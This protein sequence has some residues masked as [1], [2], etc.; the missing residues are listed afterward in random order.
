MSPLNPLVLSAGVDQRLLLCNPTRF[1][2]A[3]PASDSRTSNVGGADDEIAGY[4]PVLFIVIYL[5][6]VYNAAQTFILEK[7]SKAREG[8]RMQG[9]R[10]RYCWR[11]GCILPRVPA[12]SLRAGVGNCTLIASWYV[13]LGSV[14]FIL[15][16]LMA[17]ASKAALFASSS[18]LLLL[19]GFWLSLIAFMAFS[20][21][22]HTLF[23]E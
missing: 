9:K 6:A 8:L 10:P 19:L 12:I 16:L 15:A 7:E 20:F 23:S 13:S 3:R 21:A 17:I 11:L 5:Y 18:F 1:L 14:Y 22:V 4:L 2:F